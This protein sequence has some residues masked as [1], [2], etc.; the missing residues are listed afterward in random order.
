MTFKLR[1]DRKVKDMNRFVALCGQGFTVEELAKRYKCSPN[2]IWNY[3]KKWDCAPV[4]KP[5]FSPEDIAN[6]QEM[7]EQGSPLKVIA[8]E[9]DTHISVISKLLIEHKKYGHVDE[10]VEGM[11]STALQ[12][13]PAAGLK[14][15]K[16][17]VI[18]KYRMRRWVMVPLQEYVSLKDQ[19]NAG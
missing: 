9:Y 14:Y 19:A 4:K 6:I 18:T 12:F 16:S 17:Y 3:M 15:D 2:T 10:C 1:K 7:R 13:I 11:D 5:Q 8:G